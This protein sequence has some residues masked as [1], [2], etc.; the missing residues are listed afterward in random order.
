MVSEYWWP[1]VQHQSVSRVD[2]SE[3]WK[4]SSVL[5]ALGFLGLPTTFDVLVLVG[6]SFQSLPSSLGW[7]S[8]M[9]VCLDFRFL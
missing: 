6:T 3:Y 4:G 8:P 5:P 9:S 7:Y 2:G 1:E